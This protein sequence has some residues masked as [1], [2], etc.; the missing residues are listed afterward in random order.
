M[1]HPDFSVADLHRPCMTAYARVLIC[2]SA[3]NV[4]PLHHIL[5]RYDRE[6]EKLVIWRC[7]TDSA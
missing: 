5:L 3:Q 4:V 7:V 1:A 6:R 2:M